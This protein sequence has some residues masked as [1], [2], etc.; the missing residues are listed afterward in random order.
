M[1]LRICLA[2]AAVLAGTAGAQAAVTYGAVV[3]KFGALRRNTGAVSVALP[4]I[5]EYQVTFAPDVS[6]CT[7][8]VT[9]ASGNEFKGV[10]NKPGFLSAAV[11]VDDPHVVLVEGRDLRRAL[12]NY[13]F[14]LLVAC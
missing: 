14:H 3:N 2:L 12:H 6:A 10:D 11:S 5:G 4:V 1:R 9:R 13:A 8:V 7:I